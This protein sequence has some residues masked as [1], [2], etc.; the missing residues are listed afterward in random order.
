MAHPLDVISCPHTANKKW[1]RRRSNAFLQ[2][3]EEAMLS[4]VLHLVPDTL[5]E[6]ISNARFVSLQG[7][8]DPLSTQ[9]TSAEYLGSATPE[10]RCLWWTLG[11]SRSSGPWT[12]NS[13]VRSSDS[14]R[15]SSRWTRAWVFGWA[16]LVRTTRTVSDADSPSSQLTR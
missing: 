12:R 8:S 1:P 14:E 10:P 5:R 4:Q 2:K 11:A 15:Q 16:W 9:T 6:S 7:A 13:G 3:A